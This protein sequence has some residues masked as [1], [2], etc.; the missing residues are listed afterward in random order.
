MNSRA[1]APLVIV[2]L[3]SSVACQSQP[4]PPP[5]TEPKLLSVHKIWDGAPHNAFTSLARYRGSWYCAFRES[6][7]HVPGT[8]GR[9]RVLKSPDGDAWESVALVAEPG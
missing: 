2:L 3:L 9:I 6:S 1:L 8:N 5:L 4:K 7:A